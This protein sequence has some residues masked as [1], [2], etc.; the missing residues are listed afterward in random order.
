MRLQSGTPVRI[1]FNK[2]D[3]IHVVGGSPQANS[4]DHDLA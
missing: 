1:Y 3:Q 4:T 2:I